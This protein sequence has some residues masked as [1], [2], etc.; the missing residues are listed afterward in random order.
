LTG[1]ASHEPWAILCRHPPVPEVPQDSVTPCL[2]SGVRN[3]PSGRET[4]AQAA[5]R[6]VL[7]HF[8]EA[9]TRRCGEA[10]T[11]LAI[12]SEPQFQ[13]EILR[14]VTGSEDRG[15]CVAAEQ[16]SILGHPGGSGRRPNHAVGC[17]VR[18][19]CS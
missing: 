13:P 4:A 19:T 1:G 8:T 14:R 5:D 15:Y 12:V 16:L 9:V 6:P 10:T 17:P 7:V 2:V 11:V 3:M 18:P